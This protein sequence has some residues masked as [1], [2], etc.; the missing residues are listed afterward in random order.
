MRILVLAPQP[1]FTL[2]GTPI[3]VRML[4]DT[5]A[6]GG[7]EIDVIT[8]AE[9]DPVEIEG[10]RFLR[11][12]DLPFLRGIRPGFSL[13]KGVADLIMAWMA[14]WRLIVNRYDVI[15]AVE[16]MAYVAHG[17]RPIF[18]VP[19]V[20]DID[21]SIP[22]QLDEKYTLPRPLLGFL[23][24][25]EARTLRRAAAALACCPALEDMA[26]KAAPDLP[27]TTLTDVSLLDGAV[28]PQ[29]EV[30]ASDARFDDPVVMYVGNLEHYQGIDLLMEG[31]ALAVAKR[32]MHLVVIGGSKEDIAR[33]RKKAAGMGIG[34]VTHFL[35][36]RPISAL[37][38]YLD[39]ADI[40]ASPR[41]MGVNT[42]MKVYSY[43]DSG[44]PLL[45]TDLSTHTQVIGGDIAWLAAPTPEAMAE[46]LLELTGDPQA[47]AAM[48][49]RARERVRKDFSS[50]AFRKRLLDFYAKTVAPRLR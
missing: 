48:A 28:V 31:V 13:K 20:I 22:Q 27:V 15:H 37:A 44:S 16:E 33:Y 34:G 32:R 41:L 43:L 6:G 4:L 11:V 10:V 45:A 23:E 19:Y 24:W 42:P 17:L 39:A 46:G 5:L 36:P 50:T 1:F 26:R 47:A 40:V 30:D 38:A 8:F 12:P 2:R 29:E 49:R 25:I 14:M 35:G 3:A 18:R 21:S 9:G 7:H